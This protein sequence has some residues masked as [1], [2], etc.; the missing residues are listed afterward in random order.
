MTIKFPDMVQVNKKTKFMRRIR[1]YL[2]FKDKSGFFV[3]EWQNENKKWESYNAEIMI[4]IADAINND[5]T[6]V[7][8]TCQ[9]RSYDI[10]LTKLIQ[11]NTSTNVIRKIRCVKSM[12]RMS[13]GAPTTSSNKRPLENDDEEEEEEEE[14][15]E[16]LPPKSTTK[17]RAVS[18]LSEADESSGKTNGISFII[19]VVSFLQY[20]LLLQ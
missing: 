2:E 17:K 10:D 3:Y 16:K 9:N 18:K 12:A 7:S 13:S 6:T 5:Q 19:H 14:E 4:K 15:E 20:A 8:V 1:L 11:K